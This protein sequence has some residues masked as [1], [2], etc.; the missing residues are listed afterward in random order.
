MRGNFLSLDTAAEPPYHFL[1]KGMTINSLGGKLSVLVAMMFISPVLP[2]FQ[3]QA[4]PVRLAA[5]LKKSEEYCR[6]LEKAALDFICLEE[7]KEFS[8]Y[9]TPHTDIYLYDYQFIRKNEEIKERRNLIAVNGKKEN[10]QDSSLKSVMFQYRNVLFG[11]VGLLSKSWQVQHE[12]K[13]IGEDTIHKEKA[14]VIE[15]TPRLPLSE[16]HCYGKIWIKEDDGSVLKIL[17]DQKSL[18]NFQSVEEWVKVHDAEPQITAFSEYGFEKNGLRFPSR[19]YTEQAYIRKDK[20]KFA[21]AEISISYKDYK[22][23]TV[24]TEIK[25]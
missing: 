25:Y 2:G 4:D 22:F 11:P 7:V 18:G 15:A 1:R 10:I 23:F 12:F 16:P 20:R 21:N 9:Y 19:N 5:I 13:L 17:W 3:D 14:V 24:E 6:R 8:R